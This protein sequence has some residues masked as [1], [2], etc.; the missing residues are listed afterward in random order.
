ME[1]FF[2]TLIREL[3]HFLGNRTRDEARLDIFEFSDVIFNRQRRHSALDD[4]SH[5]ESEACLALRY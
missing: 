4:R 5:S 1:S 3:T 2:A